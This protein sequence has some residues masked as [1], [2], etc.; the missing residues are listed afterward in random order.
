MKFCIIIR[1]RLQKLY[2][3]LYICTNSIFNLIKVVVL[4]NLYLYDIL[5]L[6][7][8]TGRINLC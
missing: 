8:L 3:V 4:I 2:L 7:C 1:K 6:G 5:S